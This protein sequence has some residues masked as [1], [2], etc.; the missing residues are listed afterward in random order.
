[1]N[2]ILY[3]FILTRKWIILLRGLYDSDR[4]SLRKRI[5]TSSESSYLNHI[6]IWYVSE[7]EWRYLRFQN[8]LDSMLHS[9]PIEITHSGSFRGSLGHLLDNT[10][11]IKCTLC[12]LYLLNPC[13]FQMKWS[14]FKSKYH[15]AGDVENASNFYNR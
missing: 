10:Y 15:D 9:S 13:V 3:D 4:V 11:M 7:I 6:G 2:T 8:S 5:R 14:W 12:L 1:M